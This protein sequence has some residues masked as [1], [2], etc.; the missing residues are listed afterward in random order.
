MEEKIK[1]RTEGI[2]KKITGKIEPTPPEIDR[3]NT[4]T[5][6]RGIQDV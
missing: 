6:F 4:L 1:M 2:V 3:T 5:I